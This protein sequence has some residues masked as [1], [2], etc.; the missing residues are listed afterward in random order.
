MATIAI[1][2]SKVPPSSSSSLLPRVDQ[3]YFPHSALFPAFT[4]K[5]HL[6]ALVKTAS[7]SPR[8][9][10]ATSETKSS[11]APAS[12]DERVKQVHT[13]DEFDAALRSAEN[14]LVVV[15]YAASHSPN[16][17]R[18]YPHMQRR[19]LPPSDGRRVGAD[20]GAVPAGGHR[21]RAPLHLLQ[22]HGEGARGGG[23]RAGSARGRRALLPRQPFQGGADALEGGREGHHRQEPGRRR[24]AGGA[25][26]GAEALRALPEGVPHGD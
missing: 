8:A 12:K 25:R 17:R 9:S 24:Q 21:E 11:P 7:S 16:S 23:H 3:R 6:P 4:K 10:A 14:K 15:E 22:V 26:R 20:P 13:I 1:F 5:R 19:G 18:I 2:L